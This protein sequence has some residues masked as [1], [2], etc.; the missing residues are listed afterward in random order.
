MSP[1]G[2]KKDT[3]HDPA[4]AVSL[5]VVGAGGRGT[6]YATFAQTYPDRAR[7]VGVAEPRPFYRDRLVRTHGIP[8]GHVFTDWRQAADRPRFADAV[9][10]CTQDAMHADP[11]VARQDP[12]LILSGPEETLES[13]LIVF[14]AE[15]A[16]HENRVVSPSDV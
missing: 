1:S 11:A 9:L 10:I 12:S 14:A 4:G 7:V 5:V 6:Q 8:P 15:K 2:S 13:H 3:R 16:R